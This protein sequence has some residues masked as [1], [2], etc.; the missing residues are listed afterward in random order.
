[1]RSL[2]LELVRGLMHRPNLVFLG[3]CM[4][5]QGAAGWFRRSSSGTAQYQLP[6]RLP[7]VCRPGGGRQQQTQ[8]QH[9]LLWQLSKRL[10][11]RG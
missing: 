9:R 4:H 1:M 10:E 5:H 7:D 3:P 2:L 8:L 6:V 11:C